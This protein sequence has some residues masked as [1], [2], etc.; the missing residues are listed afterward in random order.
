[1]RLS[2]VSSPG[3]WGVQGLF[4]IVLV[5]GCMREPPD[6][7]DTSERVVI[8][9]E[10]APRDLDPRYASDAS[11]T[12]VARLIHCS[13]FTVETNDL[14]PRLE[15]A[16]RLEPACPDG[17]AECRHWVIHLKPGIYWHDGVEVTPADV[18]Y[19]FRSMIE[20]HR[21]SPF[22]GELRR[23][24]K[25]VWVEGEAVHFLLSTPYASFP[26]DLAVGLVPEHVLAPRGGLDGAF[27]DDFVG[28]GPYR[29]LG[30]Y[31]D[32]KVMLE[33]SELY[34][35]KGGPQY[36][37]VRTVPD[38]ATRVLSMM[39]GSG[40]LVVNALSPPV[41]QRLQDMPEVEISHRPAACTTYLSFNLLDHRLADLRVRQAIAAGIDRESL[42]AEQFRGMAQVATGIIPPLHWA[43]E[44]DV[45]GHSYDPVKARELLDAAGLYPDPATGLRTRFTLKVTPD[46][47]RKNI[48]ALIA[49]RLGELGIEVDLLPLELSTFLADVRSGNYEL[50]ILQLPQVI[51][52]DI[53][54]WL[55]YSQAAPRL[56][57]QPGA[58]RFGQVDRTLLPPHFNAVDGPLA[59]ECRSRWYPRVLLQLLAN[60]Q[61]IQAG[62]NPAIGSG[63]RSFYMN[64]TLDC[65]LDLGNLA[66]TEDKRLPYYREAQRIMAHDLPVLAL[67]HEDNIAV[68]R[69][70]VS[71]Y[72]LLPLNRYSPILDV[73]INL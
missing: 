31:R 63:N 34:W 52:P 24:M 39:A 65:L 57:P 48:G 53:L 45:E 55:L 30:R 8:L 60:F 1:M 66:M 58:S 38:E 59:D 42:V 61:Q 16:S 62:K 35:K 44:E 36:V 25:K 67:W 51:D 14:R 41:V 19:T 11:S 68:T 2:W 37:V 20:G 72:Q 71:G 10:S 13:L 70:G 32:Q 54:R 22:R 40:Q 73:G 46:F 49:H 9:I 6:P 3:S 27:D 5:W 18:V 17:P 15:A 12:K 7:G 4:C 28:C 47:F 50:Y 29:F 21:P 23:K 69:R 56:V 26:V 64:P 43:Y 33:K